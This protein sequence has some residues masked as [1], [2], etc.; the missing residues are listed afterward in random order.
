MCVS[1][2]IAPNRK[3]CRMSRSKR[4]VSC[5]RRQIRNYNK[6]GSVLFV[7]ICHVCVNKFSRSKKGVLFSRGVVVVVSSV[8]AL[9][10]FFFK[11][12]F[13]SYHRQNGDY[14]INLVYNCLSDFTKFI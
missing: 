1:V 13:L 14:F 11:S 3:M 5:S 2:C 6:V 9:I 7:R 8:K 12:L 4:R 10:K